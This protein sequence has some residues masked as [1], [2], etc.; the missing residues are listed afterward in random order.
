MLLVGIVSAFMGGCIMTIEEMA[1]ELKKHKEYT[2]YYHKDPDGDAVGTAFALGLVL[3]SLGAKCRTFCDNEPDKKV[4]REIISRYEWDSVETPTAIAVDSTNSKRLG[5]Y[6]NVKIDICI[7]HH[8]NNTID[9][10]AKYVEPHTSSCAEVAYKIIKAMG[11]NVTPEIADLLFVGLLTDTFCFRAPSVT[12]DSFAAAAELAKC[13]ADTVGLTKSI[14]MRKTPGMIEFDKRFYDSILYAG[15]GKIACAILTLEDQN[16]IGDD[17]NEIFGVKSITQQIEGVE[18][19]VTILEKKPGQ[20]KASIH[21]NTY[22]D[23]AAICEELG[24]GGH[25]HAAG[26]GMMSGAPDEICKSI[27]AACEK[28]IS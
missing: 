21:T 19:G 10:P 14:Y 18:I 28:Y 12:P 24:G 20:F 4:Y 11:V 27:M 9:A 2:I 22:A 16:R 15:D 1:A 6:E 3:R 26:T 13:G 17:F 8:E 23:A 5:K 7:D 25:K